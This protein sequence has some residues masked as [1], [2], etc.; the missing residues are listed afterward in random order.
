M[1]MLKTLAVAA[2]SIAALSAHAAD[3]EAFQNATVQPGGVRT[4][5]SGINFFNVEG[6]DYGSFA[7]YGVVRFDIASLKSQF[8]AQYGVDGWVVDHI[9]LSLTQSNASFTADGAVDVYFTGNDAISIVSPSPLQYPFA[10]DFADAQQIVSYTFTQIASGTLETYSLFN[11]SASNN[12]GA[13]AL[14]ADILSDSRVTLALVE[15][16]SGVAATYAGYN[17]NT[18][19]GP[20]LNIEVSAVPE[21]DGWAMLLAGLGLIAGVVRRRM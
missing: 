17:N 12:A 19:A 15:G 1:N 14:A 21:A 6:A 3:V 2:L 18:Y 8:D 16:D 13:Q 5:G 7:S 11:R 9:S 20:T 10:G 4:G